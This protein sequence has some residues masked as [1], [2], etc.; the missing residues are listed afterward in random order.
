MTICI[1]CNYYT[2]NPRR[3]QALHAPVRLPPHFVPCFLLAPVFLGVR[4][5]G[6]G[7]RG[8]QFF[9]RGIDKLE[10]LFYVCCALRESPRYLYRFSFREVLRKYLDPDLY[11]LFASWLLQLQNLC[12]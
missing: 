3:E 4:G 1:S 11:F 9:S 2:T 5:G 12:E 8:S 10:H 7:F 6:W